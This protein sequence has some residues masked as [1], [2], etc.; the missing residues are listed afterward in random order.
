M[1]LTEQYKPTTL[2]IKNGYKLRI[3][4]PMH[5]KPKHNSSDKAYNANPKH[6][7]FVRLSKG[8]CVFLCQIIHKAKRNKHKGQEQAKYD[9][10]RFVQYAFSRYAMLTFPFHL[11][12]LLW[13][14]NQ[15]LKIM[16]QKNHQRLVILYF[17]I[18]RV[19][20][21]TASKQSHEEY[22]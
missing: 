4:L 7:R 6:Y 18:F 16:I 21:P 13:R 10:S 12:L 17:C 8:V 19:F 11:G 20:L 1:F 3:Q 15:N 22:F 5:T 9:T 2:F 14:C